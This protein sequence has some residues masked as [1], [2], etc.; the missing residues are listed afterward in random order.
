MTI[1]IIQEKLDQY[2]CTNQLEEENALKEITQEIAL[3]SLSRHEFFK[4][5]E[6]HGG[7]ALRILYGLQRFS[8]DLDFA[9]LMPDPSF[10]LLPYLNAMTNEFLEYGY[11]ISIQ[12]R[13]K[14][15]NPIQKAF[16]KDDSLG[17][18]LKLRYPML[19]GKS[20]HLKIKFEIDINPPQ[21]GSTELKYL[22]FPF[23][24]EIV[25]KD[26]PS[27]FAGKIHALLC[28]GYLKG[29]DWYDFNWYVSK[30]ST[31]NF[32]F[33][34]SALEQ[35]GP[36]MNESNAVDK[37]WLITKLNEKIKSIDWKEA[38]QDVAKFIRPIEQ[39]SLSIW[40]PAFFHSRVEKL[41]EIIS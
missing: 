32:P 34:M 23:P 19:K 25:A 6:F 2:K 4:V 9:L 12:D 21:W 36:F 20:K 15:G 37:N 38:K 8:E 26:L 31:V 24:Y 35:N 30:K 28:R 13:S 17:K 39:E 40:S 33:L 11:D 41:K 22:D 10:A 16:L 27:S 14:I 1:H 18:I 7:T 3:M 29:R 5:A